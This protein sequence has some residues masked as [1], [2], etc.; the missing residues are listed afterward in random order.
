VREL[1]DLGVRFTQSED[2]SHAYDLHREG[3]HGKRRILHADDVTGFEIERAL[4]EKARV[5]PRIQIIENTTAIDL[6][7]EGRLK[8]NR[9]NPGRVIGA[10]VW[11]EPTRSVHTLTA[12]VTILATGGAG[13]VYCYTSNPDVATGDGIAMAYRAGA[14]VANLEFIQ[15]HPTCL[16]HPEAKNFLISEALRGE[17]AILRNQAG[18]DFVKKFHPLGSLAP[19]DIVARAIDMELKKTGAPFVLLDATHLKGHELKRKFPNI[20]QTCKKY[21]IDFTLQP[22]PVVPAAHYICGGVQTDIHAQ[23]SLPGLYAIGEVACTGLHGA[24]R[25]ASNSL[26][27]AVVFAHRAAM[28]IRKN[29]ESGELSTLSRL[30]SVPDWDP[31]QA[32]PLEHQLDISAAW[33]EVRTLMWNYVGIVRSNRRLDRAARRLEVIA[34]DVQSDY[35]RFLLSRDLIELRNLVRVAQLI[36][37]CAEMRKESRGLHT[38]IDYPES[39]DE[40]LK[41]TVLCKF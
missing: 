29:K 1:I 37:R 4:V 40:Y 6:I 31:G 18:E 14:K 33:R 17:G 32:V 19:R 36:V 27:E 20:D 15:F 21:G 2:G 38:T 26:L 10:Y 12:D 30:P 25:L 24:N 22:I 35:W 16:Y 5:H 39:S 9:S 3:G 41:D 11:S 8:G 34:S 28:H 7:T 23:T 13:K